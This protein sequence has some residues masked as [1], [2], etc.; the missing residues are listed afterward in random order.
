MLRAVIW[1]FWAPRYERLYAQY[2]ALAPTRRL[3]LAH[4]RAHSVQPV[5]ILDLGCGVGQLARELSAAYPHARITAIDPSP[6]MINHARDNY[7]HPAI[8]FL[9]GTLDDLPAEVTFDLAI[10]THAFPYL[11]D[12]PGA[13]SRLYAM[14]TPGGRLLIVQGNTENLYDH[15]FFLFVKLTV[16]RSEYLP[17]RA[18][19]E[20]LTAAGFTSGTITPLPC[21]C[22]IPSISLVEG[23]R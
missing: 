7:A 21:A 19:T 2:F 22:F 15:L 5:R 20:L 16:S 1:D 3:V 12:K 4:L 11:A 9:Q 6:A 14:L 17:T 10:S 18:L 8:E 13:L 23:L